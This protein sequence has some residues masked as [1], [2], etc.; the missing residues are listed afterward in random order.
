MLKF[1][2]H[3][4]ISIEALTLGNSIVTF[5]WWCGELNFFYWSRFS[6][7]RCCCWSN[8]KLFF[9]FCRFFEWFCCAIIGQRIRTVHST[10]QIMC[11]KRVAVAQ[12][13]NVESA[14]CLQKRSSKNESCGPKV[15]QASITLFL[16]SVF[17]RFGAQEMLLVE[18]MIVR[19][20]HREE[21]ASGVQWAW[22]KPTWVAS[23]RYWLGSFVSENARY[24]VRAG[25]SRLRRWL[26]FRLATAKLISA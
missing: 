3:I 10:I 14:N 11:N 6:A 9:L 12:Q 21:F 5:Y 13:P 1:V 16:N 19:A 25:G 15:S 17:D 8:R 24:D 7:Q 20:L 26:K 22:V 2:G 18:L 4:D 23:I